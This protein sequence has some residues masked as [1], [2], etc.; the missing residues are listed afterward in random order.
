V[1]RWKRPA[2]C[3]N[4]FASA[5]WRKVSGRG[6]IDLPSS[7]HDACFN[8]AEAANDWELRRPGPNFGGHRR[9]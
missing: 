4:Q 1:V 7:H 6:I 8:H 5:R 9:H 2:P 3:W